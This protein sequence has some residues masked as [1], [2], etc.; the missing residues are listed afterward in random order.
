MQDQVLPATSPIRG[1]YVSSSQVREE[2]EKILEEIARQV[3]V[4]RIF[5]EILEVITPMF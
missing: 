2:K 4:Y 1:A 3:I 5:R